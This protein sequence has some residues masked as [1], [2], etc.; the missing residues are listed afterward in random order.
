MRAQVL[1]VD[2]DDAIRRALAERVRHWG[3]HVEEAKD[4]DEA[5]EIAARREFDLVLLDLAMPRRSGMDVLRAWADSGYG[6]DVIVLTAHGSVEAAVEAV[7]AGA[8]DFLLKP[9][10]FNL[11]ASSVQR[12]LSVRE[13]TRAN[14]AFTE[15]LDTAPI[16]L[17]GSSPAMRQLVETSDLAAQS[18][19]TILLTGESGSGKQILAESIHRRSPRRNGPFVYVNCVAISD[20]LIESTLFGHE[21][22]A[23][24]GAVARKPGRLEAATG[25]TAFLDE[26]GDITPRLQAKLLHFLESGEFERVGGTRTLHV[27]CRVIAAT[28]RNLESA[29]REQKFREDLYFR[30]NVIGLRVP[31]LRERVGDIPD[32]A[33]AFLQRYA[34]EL[35]RGRLAFA[36]RTMEILRQYTWPGNVRQLKNAVE[37]MVVL[38]RT[39]L[40]PPELLPPEIVAPGSDQPVDFAP[41]SLTLKDATQAFRKQH[42]AKALA[43]AGGNQRIAA[44]ELGLQRTFLNRLLKEYGL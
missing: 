33:T 42:L 25:G 36:E 24:S 14:Q 44:E 43:R 2:D 5:I 29:A 20:E 27:D 8:A 28:N 17:L 4:G 34:A 35:G 39:E 41:E 23:F 30:L 1:V 37:R 13:L 15:R 19:A 21:R 26:V 11:L 12:L 32:L 6:A 16:P 3:H 18:N 22:G 9:A 7:R 40:L 31:P 10:D 38:S